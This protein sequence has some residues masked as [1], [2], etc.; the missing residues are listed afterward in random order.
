MLQS[1]SAHLLSGLKDG[2]GRIYFSHPFMPRLGFEPTTVELHQP[3]AFWRLLF[4]LSY[5]TS[6]NKLRL[7]KTY[8]DQSKLWAEARIC[9]SAIVEFFC[10]VGRR[11]ILWRRD[12][13]MTQRPVLITW[14]RDAVTPDARDM[15]PN[16]I[17]RLNPF[18][19]LSNIFKLNVNTPRSRSHA[20]VTEIGL[21]E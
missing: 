3:G 19:G 9:I 4:R 12:D 14:R 17:F 16:A 5:R 7:S 8:S 20:Q 11:R 21:V 1:Q 2:T 10:V 13:E 6:K 18:S 15:S